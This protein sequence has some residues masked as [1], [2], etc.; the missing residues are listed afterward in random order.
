MIFQSTHSIQS[1]TEKRQYN[2]AKFTFI[3]I[4]ALH[5]ECDDSENGLNAPYLSNI[6]ALFWQKRI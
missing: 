6:L 5:T 4:H 3:S 2:D 1:A